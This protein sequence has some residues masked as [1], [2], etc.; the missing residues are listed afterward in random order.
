VKRAQSYIL[1]AFT[2]AELTKRYKWWAALYAGACF[3][4]GLAAVWVFNAK[5]I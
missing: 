1:S 4:L 5:F 2:Q 3:L